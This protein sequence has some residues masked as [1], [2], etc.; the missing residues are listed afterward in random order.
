M[1]ETQSL[2]ANP[3]KH[4]A[5]AEDPYLRDALDDL[6]RIHPARL[7]RLLHHTV[8]V[9]FRPDA[10]VTGHYRHIWSLLQREG[11][12]AVHA[13]P[14]RYGRPLVRECWRYQLNIATRQRIDVMDMV[15]TDQP[16]AY[17]LFRR[18]HSQAAEALCTRISR[19]KGPS[20]P[21]R[22]QPGQLRHSD[23]AAQA[24]VLTFLHVPDEPL[25]L[26]RELGAFF[27]RPD[28]LAIVR[29]VSRPERTQQ[30]LALLDSVAAQYE[31]HDLRPATAWRNLLRCARAD[32]REG[33]ASLQQ[34]WQ[35]DPASWQRILP[36]VRAL[37]PAAQRWDLVAI[38]ASS[39][40]THFAGGVPLVPDAV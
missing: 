33:L 37:H 2:T 9:L 31:P 19:L 22:R 38:A 14:F 12:Q 15:L 4:A 21:A 16:A 27:A 28:R 29:A 36:R 32:A 35:A 13:V 26:L 5:F 6:R 30:A 1:L 39:A 34:Q 20:D 18:P 7:H 23:S 8:P 17:V 24:S 3:R 11:L 25:D 40:T 10:M